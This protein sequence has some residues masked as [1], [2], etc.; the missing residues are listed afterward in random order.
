MISDYLQE[1]EAHMTFNFFILSNICLILYPE[2][3]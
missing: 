3:I 2:H 1:L